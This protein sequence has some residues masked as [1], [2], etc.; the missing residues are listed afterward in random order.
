MARVRVIT[1]Y[2]IH[3]TKLYEVVDKGKGDGLFINTTGVGLIVYLVGNFN[4]SS[5][6]E[7]H[8]VRGSG[9]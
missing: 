3:Y 2:S 6:L 4:F 9:A 1:S 5:Y 7:L 8:F